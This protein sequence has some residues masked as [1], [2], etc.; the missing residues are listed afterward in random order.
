MTA[1]LV[2]LGLASFVL[3]AALLIGAAKA[4]TR[5]LNVDDCLPDWED[6]V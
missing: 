1:F 4:L 5:Q 6:C 3:S 2:V